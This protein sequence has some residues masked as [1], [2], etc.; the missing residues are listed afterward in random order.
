MKL[1]DDFMDPATLTFLFDPENF[2]NVTQN[3]NIF[4]FGLTQLC[5]YVPS[6]SDHIFYTS[7]EHALVWVQLIAW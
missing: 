5:I 2:R 7:V 3:M 4:Y 6:L 1:F